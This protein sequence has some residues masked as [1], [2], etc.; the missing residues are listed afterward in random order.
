MIV[1]NSSAAR[2]LPGSRTLVNSWHGCRC[3]PSHCAWRMSAA[4]A[5]ALWAHVRALR[6]RDGVFADLILYSADRRS[7]VGPDSSRARPGG[8]K[9]ISQLVGELGCPDV[10]RAAEHL[11]GDVPLRNSE[12]RSPLQI[13]LAHATVAIRSGQQPLGHEDHRAVLERC[14]PRPLE[15]RVREEGVTNLHGRGRL[16]VSH[17]P[18]GAPLGELLLEFPL[19][20][21]RV[22]D[23]LADHLL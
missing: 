22:S 18:L 19:L 4:S 6:K 1:L 15:R 3:T 9:C 13:N 20:H 16:E 7:R 23:N 11:H 2:G 17:A 12:A 8:F 5:S 14:N 21:P 10:V